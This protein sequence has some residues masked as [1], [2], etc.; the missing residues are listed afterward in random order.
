MTFA[1]WS[2]TFGERVNVQQLHRQ[3]E[4]LPGDRLGAGELPEPVG[5]VDPAEAGVADAAERQARDRGEGDAPS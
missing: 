2:V 4:P 1:S 3:R 5:A